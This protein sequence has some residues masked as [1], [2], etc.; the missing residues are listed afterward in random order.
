MI[1]KF[2]KEEFEKAL[3]TDKNTGERLWEGPTMIKGELTYTI[4]VKGTN[5]RIV[6]R[7]SIDSSGFAA[8]AGADSIRLWVEYYWQ[9]RDIWRPLAKARSYTTRVSGWDVR[10]T[11]KLRELWQVA[12]DDGKATKEPEKPDHKAMEEMLTG[13]LMEQTAMK[14]D[15]IMAEE[16]ARAA[17]FA[18]E[19]A[20]TTFTPS[21]YQE[22]IR[23]AV[24]E[25]TDN[26]QV[27]AA[28]GSGKS[29]TIKWL[30]IEA[31]KAGIE[32]QTILTFAKKLQEEMK[33]KMQ[34][35]GS[36]VPVQ[37]CH[38]LGFGN[39]KQTY[40][41]AKMEAKKVYW[42]FK[43]TLDDMYKDR[44]NPT[45]EVLWA[46]RHEICKLVDHLRYHLSEPT[47]A[48]I[49]ELALEYSVDLNGD[50]ATI[51]KMVQKVYNKVYEDR[52]RFD[53]VDMIFWTAAG[54]VPAREIDILYIDES[55][56]FN[57]AMIEFALK[58][59]GENGRA[60]VVGDPD[61]SIFGFMGAD[62]EAMDR[63][64][65]ALNATELPLS[66]CYR[67]DAAIIRHAQEIYP[68]I[69]VKPN[70]AEGIV[71]TVSADDM[72]EMAGPGDLVLCRTNAPL[73]RPCYDLIRSGRKAFIVGRDIGRGLIQLIETIAEKNKA[74]SLDDLLVSLDEYARKEVEKLVRL[75]RESQAQAIQDKVETIIELS[76][77]AYTVDD[78]KKRISDIF[79][80]ADDNTAVRF[81]TVHKAKGTEA[82][83]VYILKPEL[84]PGPW[85]KTEEE[86]KQERN[87]IWVAR[88]RA[89]H[90][91]HYVR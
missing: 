46:N 62:T 24:L 66:I 4:K 17:E 74:T 5:K 64:R 40:P 28:P 21:A 39:N 10:M 30:A 82:D 54:I 61:Q 81:S 68:N 32:G 75:E 25:T 63:F 72:M 19:K 29:T 22:A 26:L 36:S 38:S 50:Q 65:K 70:A 42:T 59:L 88:T 55:Q 78:L 52:R 11:T 90:E 43:D 44:F 80:D 69:E 60:I 47:T 71:D 41:R 14:M 53:Y 79:D 1:D 31:E 84:L 57:K 8:D 35:A 16:R 48:N 37:T 33:E 56:D 58:T 86:K 2:S 3:P 6:V 15:Q 77:G 87:V 7:S 89:K 13:D 18:P 76:A 27:V 49:V 9:Q 34:L 12:V 20:D 73:V 91:L 23:K 51:V 85:A 67:C 45:R 83:V